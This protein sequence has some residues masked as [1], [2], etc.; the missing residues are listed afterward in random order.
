MEQSESR[1]LEAVPHIANDMLVLR[2]ARDYSSLRIGW[3]TW[4]VMARNIAIFFELP[5][6]GG[7][8]ND[9]LC[10]EYLSECNG[11]ELLD[12]EKGSPVAG[13]PGCSR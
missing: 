8:R 4:Y 6:T 10:S 11:F 7:R 5:N 1:L 12:E 2:Q 3:T 9:I 13:R